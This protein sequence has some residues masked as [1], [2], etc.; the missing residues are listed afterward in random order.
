MES[1]AS[2]C[3]GFPPRSCVGVLGFH[4]S[5]T[6]QTGPE[7]WSTSECASSGRGGLRALGVDFGAAGL[8]MGCLGV[9]SSL[10]ALGMKLGPLGV[11]LIALEVD[12]MPW[13]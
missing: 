4:P 9:T 2:A 7:A 11:D 3:W 8:G 5:P 12:R 6:Q 13:K 1:E 10:E